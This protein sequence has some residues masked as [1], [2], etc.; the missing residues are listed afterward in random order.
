MCVYIYMVKK[1]KQIKN[2]DT[3]SETMLNNDRFNNKL[4]KNYQKPSMYI[5]PAFQ[6]ITYYIIYKF[7][8]NMK[9]NVDCICYDNNLLE[10][11]NNF[12]FYNITLYMFI[13]TYVL[14][15][16]MYFNNLNYT[17]LII[18]NIVYTV[19]KIYYIISWRKLYS[20]IKKNNC[21]CAKTTNSKAINFIVWLD[22]ILYTIF[23]FILIFLIYIYFSNPSYI[24]NILSMIKK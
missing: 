21:D 10:K 7:V 13:I 9:K 14:V 15:S 8:N 19:I 17:L 3:N 2:T 23:I 20:N 1:N 22:I 12:S 18:L 16:V 24:F 4:S 11:F 6:I 5:W